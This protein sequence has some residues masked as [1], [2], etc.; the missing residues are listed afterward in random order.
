MKM[1]TVEIFLRKV[2]TNF[3]QDKMGF[4]IGI[5]QNFVLDFLITIRLQQ[6]TFKVM[7]KSL[8]CGCYAMLSPLQN[9]IW[10]K[11]SLKYLHFSLKYLLYVLKWFEG[12]N[13]KSYP[14]LIL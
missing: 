5:R 14:F 12:F 1:L 10:L 2:K 6:N 8:K 9:F 4:T 7:E 13:C 3:I 11:L